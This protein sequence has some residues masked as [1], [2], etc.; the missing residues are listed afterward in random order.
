MIRMMNP[1]PPYTMLA[2]M[3][4]KYT[5]LHNISVHTYRYVATYIHS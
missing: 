1:G 2:G 3:M 4:F 5:M